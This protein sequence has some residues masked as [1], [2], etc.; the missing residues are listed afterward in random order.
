MG[1]KVPENKS[2]REG[3]FPRTV[4]VT[5]NTGGGNHHFRRWKTTADILKHNRKIR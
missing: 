2:S 3:K 1:A 5:D 4:I